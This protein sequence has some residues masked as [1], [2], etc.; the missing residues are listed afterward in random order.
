MYVSV[1]IDIYTSITSDIW[2]VWNIFCVYAQLKFIYVWW[3]YH[4]NCKLEVGHTCITIDSY[5][6]SLIVTSHERHGVSNYWQIDC[7]FLQ[8]HR[9]TWLSLCDEKP[10][11]TSAFN[12]LFAPKL[13]TLM[14]ELEMIQTL[15]FLQRSWFIVINKVM[16]VIWERL[17]YQDMLV[18]GVGNHLEGY[19]VR[20]L[21]RVSKIYCASLGLIIKCLYMQ[22][23]L[24]L[25]VFGPVW[26][27]L[28]NNVVLKVTAYFCKLCRQ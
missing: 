4:R 3:N 24:Q 22:K 11:V 17:P 20:T 12:S 1:H 18:T 10:L 7:F 8:F 15:Y 9:S 19:I 2:L 23:C 14:T 13:I 25:A 6:L 27:K 21:I 26:A 16:K 5:F 28:Y